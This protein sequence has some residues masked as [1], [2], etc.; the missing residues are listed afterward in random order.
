MLRKVLDR[1]R[2]SPKQDQFGRELV[3]PKPIEIPAG[4]K[5][6]ESINEM[7][8][9]LVKNEI[10]VMASRQGF[11]TLDEASDFEVDGDHFEDR[12]S[13]HQLMAEEIEENEDVREGRERL[14]RRKAAFERDR[15]RGDSDEERGRSRG[16]GEEDAER[17][18][19]SD[20]RM[21]GDGA[22][23]RSRD[24]VGEDEDAG[25]RRGSGVAA[26]QRSRSDGL[27]PVGRRT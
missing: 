4:M 16:R 7:M 20:R 17:S 23:D 2:V 18:G 1:F 10:S 24:R 5:R 11:E 19:Q 12:M 25:E 13:R 3:D 22:V 26:R 27:G 15:A 8:A 21:Q 9:R 6:P 14:A